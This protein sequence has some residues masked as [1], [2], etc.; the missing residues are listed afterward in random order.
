VRSK[1]IPHSALA[2]P[3][4]GE[5]IALKF[6]GRTDSRGARLLKKSYGRAPGSGSTPAAG[7]N[8]ALC[9][10][11]A[12]AVLWLLTAA[13][14]H[15]LGAPQ[16]AGFIPIL[17]TPMLVAARWAAQVPAGFG[18]WLA[19]GVLLPGALWH[20]T[21]PLLKRRSGDAVFA[22]LLALELFWLLRWYNSRLPSAGAPLW[23]DLSRAQQASLAL[24]VLLIV[25]L[26]AAWLLSPDTRAGYGSSAPSR[27]TSFMRKRRLPSRIAGVVLMTL[28][29]ALIGF[30]ILQLEA[31]AARA[32]FFG[33]LSAP[34]L[35]VF[36]VVLDAAY[37]VG[38]KMWRRLT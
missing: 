32:V 23:N 12:C 15:V 27:I 26:L 19:L 1:N 34:L 7:R 9:L 33:L 29:I 2:V 28:A 31:D 35:F 4:S 18:W 11:L 22:A 38:R 36:W 37:L 30:T 8:I 10:A 5:A 21:A 25:F 16:S 17:L 13:L 20:F 6:S 24:G 3:H 14:R